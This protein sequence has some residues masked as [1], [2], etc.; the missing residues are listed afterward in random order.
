MFDT[1]AYVRI[2]I[3]GGFSEAQ[4]TAQMEALKLVLGDLATKQDLK[5][6]SAALRQEM[7]DLGVALRAEI[8]AVET[9]LRGESK[10]LRAELFGLKADLLKWVVGLMIA[11]TGL[12]VAL[13]KFF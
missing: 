10:D 9:S 1:H 4:A 5:D 13:L 6:L 2:L 7:K 3:E 11:Q 12:I 8:K